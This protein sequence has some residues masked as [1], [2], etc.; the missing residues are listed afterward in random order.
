MTEDTE[1]YEGACSGQASYER[2][3]SYDLAG[4]VIY[5]GSVAQGSSPDNFSYDAA[6]NPTEISS[7]DGSGNFDTYD[8][9][10][11]ALGEVTDELR[12][13]KLAA[14]RRATRT[15]RSAI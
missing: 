15:A 1:V 3:Y 10:F 5:Q 13:G 12:S 11:G 6:G 9:S 7:H 4:Q 14:Q 2:N 8:Q